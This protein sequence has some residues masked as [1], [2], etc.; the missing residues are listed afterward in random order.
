M[1]DN[2]NISFSFM[3]EENEENDD[4]VGDDVEE[5]EK[6]NTKFDVPFDMYMYL[7]D[8]NNVDKNENTKYDYNDDLIASQ[9]LNYNMN[10]TVKDLLLISDYYG[11][12]K[13]LKANK[14]NK[15][16]IINFLVMFEL[17]PSN[18]DIVLRRQNAW[19][20]INELKND[21]FMRK[22]VLW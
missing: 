22:Y 16:Q 6:E 11:F 17:D 3:E 14:Y 18:F 10:C 19:F 5:K 8:V 12:S 7:N 15:E 13:E 1:S 20:Y 21:K 9:S 4:G 2:Q